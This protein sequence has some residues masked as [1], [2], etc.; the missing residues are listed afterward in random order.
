MGNVCVPG[1][2]QLVCGV[3]VVCPGSITNGLCCVSVCKKCVWYLSI[4]LGDCGKVT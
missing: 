1:C 3:C 2:S 4:A